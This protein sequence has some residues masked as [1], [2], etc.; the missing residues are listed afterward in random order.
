VH[1]VGGCQESQVIWGR[2]RQNPA[3]YGMG[4]KDK[5]VFRL[6][7]TD[8]L[9]AMILF[10]HLKFGLMYHIA[11]KIAGT[12]G[13][14]LN[15]GVKKY[16][17]NYCEI[18]YGPYCRPIYFRYISHHTTNRKSKFVLRG[19]LKTYFGCYNPFKLIMRN[20]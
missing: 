9:E 17:I 4:P 5:A 6:L 13:I 3:A 2:P 7:N 18:H 12:I 8:S 19:G 16:I 15:G 14:K 10:F 20:S 11:G 1:L